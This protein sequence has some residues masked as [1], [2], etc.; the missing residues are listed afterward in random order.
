M[1]I[2]KGDKVVVITGRDKGKEGIV[3]KHILVLKKLSLKV[4][5]FVKNIASQH[6]KIL[7][8]QS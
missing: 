2:K 7:K 3:Q 4:L 1:L 6:N 8:D 5:I